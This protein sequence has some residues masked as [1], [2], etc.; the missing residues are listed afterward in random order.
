MV[1]PQLLDEIGLALDEGRG[2]QNACRRP[3][4]PPT[5]QNEELHEQ[6]TT[7]VVVSRS[8]GAVEVEVPDDVPRNARG[9]ARLAL[10][11][12]VGDDGEPRTFPRTT[13]ARRPGGVRLDEATA[14]TD[15]TGCGT[16]SVS[17]KWSLQAAAD[18]RAPAGGMSWAEK[19]ASGGLCSRKTWTRSS[20]TWRPASLLTSTTAGWRNRPGILSRGLAPRARGAAVHRVVEDRQKEGK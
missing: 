2:Q 8:T 20:T 17:G 1:Q 5:L 10:C 9:A 11:L 16:T 19:A 6:R 14:A 4:R 7:K 18:D 12:G 15:G 3:P 13:P